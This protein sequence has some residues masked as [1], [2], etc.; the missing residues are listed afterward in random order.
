VSG[1]SNTQNPL[2]SSEVEKRAPEAGATA[3]RLRSKQAGVWELAGTLKE[4]GSL[5]DNI[6]KAGANK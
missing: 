5:A 1:L 6:S 4:N 2:V 3:S